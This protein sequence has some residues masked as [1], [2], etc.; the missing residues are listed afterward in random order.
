MHFFD[1]ALRRPPKLCSLLLAALVIVAFLVYV[2]TMPPE[3]VDQ[4]V[5]AVATEEKNDDHFEDI[6]H[7]LIVDW[8][9]CR[10]RETKRNEKCFG[11]QLP[12][13]AKLPWPL[14]RTASE[15]VPA[16]ITTFTPALNRA[17][18]TEMLNLAHVFSEFMIDHGF[19]DK[20]FLDSGSLLGSY[21]HHDFIPWDDDFD[22]A[23]DVEVREDIRHLIRSL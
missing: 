12:E 22:F 21:R 5:S 17:L 15:P 23:V 11:R 14:A 7:T 1:R 13:L 19:A 2:Q 16:Y 18:R 8:C 3:E 9:D 20:Y 10:V 4:V 6:N